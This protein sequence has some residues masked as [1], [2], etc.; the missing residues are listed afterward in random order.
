METLNL[1]GMTYHAKEERKNRVNLIESTIGFGTVSVKAPDLYGKE[2]IE[3]I[4]TSTG[5]MAVHD[6]VVDEIVSLW[7]ASPKQVVSVCRRAGIE[8]VPNE[9]WK[10]VNY[11]SNTEW[12]QKNSKKRA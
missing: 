12:Y 8:K 5:V 11:Y 7:I 3:T 1:A 9:I 4:L 10:R 6:K 2:N